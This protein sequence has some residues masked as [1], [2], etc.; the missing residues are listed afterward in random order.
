MYFSFQKL[1]L[2][3][4]V[5]LISII[6]ACSKSSNNIVQAEIDSISESKAFSVRVES[7]EIERLSTGAAVEIETSEANSEDLSYMTGPN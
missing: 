5:F 7:V 2:I 3:P 1:K 4:T 6:V